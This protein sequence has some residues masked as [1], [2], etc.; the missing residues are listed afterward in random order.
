MAT[1]VKDLLE[2]F[3]EFE[4]V[5]CK[6]EKLV[7]AKLADADLLVDPKV[8]GE[9]AGLAC[10]YIAAHLIAISPCG[11]SAG[12]SNEHGSSAYKSMVKEL[13]TIGG[14]VG[15]RVI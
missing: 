2:S 15:C 4:D 8:Y 3:P 10:K 7:K 9:K 6:H 12:L 13:K 14:A 5:A 11:K 1:T